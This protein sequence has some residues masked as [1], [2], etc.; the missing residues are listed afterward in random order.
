MS[1][2]ETAAADNDR[3]TAPGQLTGAAIIVASGI[4][5]LRRERVHVEAEHP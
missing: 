1:S 5:L 3:A 2:H 4:Y